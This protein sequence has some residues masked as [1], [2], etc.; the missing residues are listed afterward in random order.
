MAFTKNRN[1][2]I[3]HLNLLNYIWSV[4]TCHSSQLRLIP[5]LHWG[6]KADSPEVCR[7]ATCILELDLRTCS[8]FLLIS[9]HD[10]NY[11]FKKTRTNENVILNL[12]I[13]FSFMN[14]RQLIFFT[15][16]LFQN[17]LKFEFN[18]RRTVNVLKYFQTF[19]MSWKI[20]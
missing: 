6:R 10:T 20:T 1:I 19:S 14:Y 16:F 9:C 5:Y 11:L 2:Y 4:A 17:C 7:L 12:G 8:F 13:I 3:L 15:E 18:I